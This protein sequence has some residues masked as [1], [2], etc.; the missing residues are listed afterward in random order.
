LTR[1]KLDRPS[2]D[3]GSVQ[4]SGSVGVNHEIPL[5]DGSVDG[6]LPFRS[7]DM[8]RRAA[9]RHPRNNRNGPGHGSDRAR[10]AVAAEY[11]RFPGKRART[12]CRNADATE[13]PGNSR[14]TFRSRHHQRSRPTRVRQR[15]GRRVRYRLLSRAPAES[16]KVPLAVRLGALRQRSSV[17]CRAC[18]TARSSSLR[19]DGLCSRHRTIATRRGDRPC[20]TSRA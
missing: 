4:A 7:S 9:R 3:G 10:G 1:R 14:H 2:I 5:E 18:A 16:P 17:D 12:G 6:C 15:L 13:R 11:S 19:A 20:R 8:C